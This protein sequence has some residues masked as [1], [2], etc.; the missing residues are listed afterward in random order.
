MKALSHCSTVCNSAARRGLTAVAAV[1]LRSNKR[2]GR[3]GL[4]NFYPLFS[5]SNSTYSENKA[6][7]NNGCI[8]VQV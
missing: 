8:T 7:E 3:L 2:V 6:T 5:D 4:P 1:L